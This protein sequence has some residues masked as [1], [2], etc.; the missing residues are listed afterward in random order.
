MIAKQPAVPHGQFEA[1]DIQVNVHGGGESGRPAQP[2]RHH[3]RVIDYDASLKPVRASWLRHR[4]AAKWNVKGRFALC[5]PPAS[6][7]EALIPF[8][9]R[10]GQRAFARTVKKPPSG[11]F[12]VDCSSICSLAERPTADAPSQESLALSAVAE[13][14]QTQMPE[15]SLFT[16]S[17]APRWRT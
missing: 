16:D 5:T 10:M 11:G 4:D 2:A 1:F 7:L 15:P 9:L 17:A 6:S 12:F 8:L 14:I 3:P 13:N